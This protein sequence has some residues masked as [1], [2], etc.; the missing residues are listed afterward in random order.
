FVSDPLTTIPCIIEL[1]DRFGIFSGYKLNY[2]KSEC[3]LVNNPA[4]QI[5]DGDLPF[6]MSGDSFKYLGVNICRHLST[7]YQNNF[8][9]LMEQIKLDLER[10]KALHLTIAGRINCIK[11]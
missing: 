3:F 7:I 9:P 8:L 10:W 5:T 11:M 1:L 2:S 4:P 6:K